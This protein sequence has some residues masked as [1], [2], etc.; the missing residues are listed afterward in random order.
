V[1]V[2][3]VDGKPCFRF[4]FDRIHAL[5]A[6]NGN[7]TTEKM[8]HLN[9]TNAQVTQVAGTCGKNTTNVSFTFSQHANGGPDDLK[10]VEAVA[11]SSAADGW[12]VGNSMDVFG[13]SQLAW[14]DTSTIYCQNHSH[15]SDIEV[16]AVFHLDKADSIKSSVYVVC[17]S[18]CLSLSL[19]PVLLTRLS[20][21]SEH[22]VS[23]RCGCSLVGIPFGV[24]C[25]GGE[26]APYH[27][28][29]CQ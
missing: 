7:Q 22:V 4:I 5:V 20:P 2:K 28:C 17:L 25:D 15:K 23:V 16:K 24:W 1:T 12:E 8:V 6:P 21:D 9:V 26:P 27:S 18:L 13:P 11:T 3:G 14:E 29:S 10:G 19:P